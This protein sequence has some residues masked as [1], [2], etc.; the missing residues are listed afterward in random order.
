MPKNAYPASLPRNHSSPIA[1]G[2]VLLAALFATGCK[3]TLEIGAVLPLS[4]DAQTLGEDSRRG[5]ELA[6]EELRAQGVAEFELLIADSAS[7]PEKAAA[8]LTALIDGGAVAAI[9]GV[10][11]SEARAL[12]PV[13]IER[14]RV[15]VSPSASDQ[16]ISSGSKLVYR[17]SHS[18]ADAGSTFATLAKKLELESAVVLAADARYADTLEEGFG[19]TFG[20]LGGNLGDRLEAD[21][22]QLAQAVATITGSAPDLVALSGDGDWIREAVSGLRGA[23]YKGRLFAP[24][25]FVNPSTLEALGGNTASTVLFAHT[26]FDLKKPTPEAQTFADAYRAKY[27][28]DPSIFAA[29]AYDSLKVLVTA[30]QDRPALPG[31]VRRALRDEIKSYPG[32]TGNLE[33]DGTGSVSKFPRVFGIDS[34]LAVYDYSDWMEQER[35]RIEDEKRAL[36]EK[37]MKIRN[38]ASRAAGSP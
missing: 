14:E 22:A 15:L 20:S 25:A 33:F 29:E 24:Q 13:A 8:E 9:G 7:D 18:D 4:G 1:L 11:N 30:M 12:A 37:L 38:Q 23:G 6:A 10:T 32:V 16:K 36:R 21:E 31:E 27:G 34:Q 26:A 28:E 19:P 2:A 5:L 17:I 3:D 35:Q